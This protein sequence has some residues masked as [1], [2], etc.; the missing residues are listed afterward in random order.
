MMHG[1]MSPPCTSSHYESQAATASADRACAGPLRVVFVHDQFALLSL[2]HNDAWV[3]V[4]DLSPPCMAF[5][6]KSQAA[7]ATTDRVCKQTRPLLVFRFALPRARNK[8]VW[9]PCVQTCLRV[10]AS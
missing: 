3:D 10:A 6:L 9:L 7:T 1:W 8:Y 2:A 5:Q 4:A